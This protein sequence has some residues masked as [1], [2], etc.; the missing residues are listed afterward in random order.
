MSTWWCPCGHAEQQEHR[1][2]I[3][4][5][6]GYYPSMYAPESDEDPREVHRR[7]VEVMSR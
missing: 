1:E 6:Y 2:A 5:K 3:K 4:A 7:A